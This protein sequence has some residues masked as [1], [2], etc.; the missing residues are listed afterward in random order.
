[1]IKD[2][3]GHTYGRLTVTEAAESIKGKGAWLC[4]CTCGNHKVVTGDSL[5]TGK[6]KSCGCLQAEH[7]NAGRPTHGMSR[8]PT[9]KSWQEM[10]TRCEDPKAISFP[11]Y[12]GRGIK[13]CER[14]RNSFENFLE[15]MG[16][17]PAG[18]SLDRKR[19]AEGYSPSNCVWST[20]TEQNRNKRSNVLVKYKGREQCLSAWCEELKIPYGRTYHRIV[21]KGWPA[22][23]AFE[24]PFVAYAI[25]HPKDRLTGRSHMLS[26]QGMTKTLTQWATALGMSAA[27]LTSRV[28]QRGWDIERAFTQPVK[29]VA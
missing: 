15:D 26:Y 2:E 11:N 8:T 16:P 18:R 6:I 4:V 13:V 7:R 22:A 25:R 20:R 29:G 24:A 14:W 9:Y 3:M 28:V 17:R 12:G 1:M 5:R 10:R 21:I 19:G 27:T 23:I